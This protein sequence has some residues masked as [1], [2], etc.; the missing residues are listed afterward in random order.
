[1]RLPA[2]CTKCGLYFWSGIEVDPEFGGG[3]FIGNATLCP[4]CTGLAAVLDVNFVKV[5]QQVVE[6]FATFRD[7]QRY[8][9][10]LS[11][12]QSCIDFDKSTAEVAERVATEP[13]FKPLL[14]LFK[15]HKLTKKQFFAL[16]AFLTALLTA[17]KMMLTDAET[18]H[19]NKEDRNQIRVEDST[20]TNIQQIFNFMVEKGVH[21][22]VVFEPTLPSETQEKK[23]LEKEVQE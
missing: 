5:G 4:D 19:A 17:V 21:Q 9:H 8:V 20:N 10:A 2:V 11:I 1:M 3:T 13:V 16:L 23:I 22:D 7:K 15:T 12:L 18:G 14:D 6:G